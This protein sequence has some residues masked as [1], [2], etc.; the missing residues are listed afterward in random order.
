MGFEPTR[1]K[2]QEPKSCAAANYATRAQA[3]AYDVPTAQVINVLA[4]VRVLGVPAAV[5]SV[6]APAHEVRNASSDVAA[7][8]EAAPSSVPESAQ[9]AVNSRRSRAT[10]PVALTL[11]W[12]RETLPSGSTT[13]V[14]RITPV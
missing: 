5:V 2:A 14:E 6:P 4:P 3:I 8:P 7:H 10:C 9:A 1:P 12:A 13:T 11:Y